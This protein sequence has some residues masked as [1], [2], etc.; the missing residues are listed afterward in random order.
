MH[1]GQNLPLEPDRPVLKPP[2]ALSLPGGAWDSP[3]VTP[4]PPPQALR[5]QGLGARRA[6][7]QGLP[8]PLPHT[9][10]R[11]E[12]E[13]VM[14]S[15]A[16]LAPLPSGCC[17]HGPA[18]GNP[19][20]WWFLGVPGWSEAGGGHEKAVLHFSP[21]LSGWLLGILPGFRGWREGR[22]RAW[23]FT[24][25]QKIYMEVGRRHHLEQPLR[26]E[27]KPQ[28]GKEALPKATGVR[29]RT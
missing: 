2:F 5:T 19:V 6:Q 21:P 18:R 8:P 23:E 17:S 22:G 15:K 13:E 9:L 28:K 27:T 29:S 11:S 25:S 14:A 16:R 24:E 20:A 1:G 4:F 26:G 10:P 7:S 3:K 12:A